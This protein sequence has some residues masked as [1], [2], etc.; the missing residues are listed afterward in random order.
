MGRVRSAKAIGRRNKD[1]GKEGER[2][3]AKLFR[4]AGFQ[5]RRG[6]QY[7]GSPDSPDV[8]HS[9]FGI[10]VEAKWRQQLNLYE[11]ISKALEDSPEEMPAIFHRKD[12]KGWLVTMRAEDWL[13][14]MGDIFE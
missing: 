11:A 10:H 13:D 9:L 3:V 8:V 14:L 1:K 6:R 12:G 7:A 4:E 5:A 2:Q